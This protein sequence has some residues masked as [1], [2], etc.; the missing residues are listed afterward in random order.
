MRQHRILAFEAHAHHLAC[1]GR[2]F[3]I[4]VSVDQALDCIWFV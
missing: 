3:L 2:H 1:E 4:R